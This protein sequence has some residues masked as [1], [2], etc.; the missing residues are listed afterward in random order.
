MRVWLEA[1][2]TEFERT[3]KHSE[4]RGVGGMQVPFFGDFASVALLPSIISR[5]KWWADR[6]REALD[7]GDDD[8]AKGG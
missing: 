7:V 3:V 1:I 2:C 8:G 5:M 6:F 4:T